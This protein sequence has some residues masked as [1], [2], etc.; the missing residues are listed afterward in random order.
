VLEVMLKIIGAPTTIARRGSKRSHPLCHLEYMRAIY[1]SIVWRK[2]HPPNY[3]IKPL[4]S[5]D[6]AARQWRR[7]HLLHISLVR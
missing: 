6:I 1:C 7:S 4:I 5:H 2:L 3:R